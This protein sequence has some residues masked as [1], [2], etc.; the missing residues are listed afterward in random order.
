M[1]HDGTI[2]GYETL[3]LTLLR[4]G[5]TGAAVLRRRSA[6]PSR[7]GAVYVHCPGDAFVRDE[8]VVWFTDRGFHFYAADLR[9]VGGGAG[10]RQDTN[11]VAADLSEYFRCLDEAVA[12][13]RQADA[14][15]TVVICAHGTGALVCALWCHARR[16]GRPADVLVLATPDLSRDQSWLARAGA[17]W[18][19][20]AAGEEMPL[21]GRV[22]PLR[23]A[24]QRRVRRG[25]DIACPVLVMCPARAWDSPAGVAGPVI[26]RALFGAPAT[27]RLGEHVTWLK[28]DGGQPLPGGPERKKFFDE[29]GRWLGAYLSGQVRDQ[30][31]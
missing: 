2:E 19:T 18:R 14:I 21:A 11:L 6:R 7:R 12:H 24:A 15:D 20:G 28:L 9:E 16:A 26:L 31:L 13:V 29:L 23:A 10:T 8:L 1:K 4:D 25:L 5:G 27:V 22:S 3:P 17:V 30:L